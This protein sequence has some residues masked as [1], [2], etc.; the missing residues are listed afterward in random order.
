MRPCLRLPCFPELHRSLLLP[1]IALAGTALPL[2]AEEPE[3]R[4]DGSSTVYPILAE[5]VP[6]YEKAVQD[7]GPVELKFS[8]TSA[9]F[10]RFVTGE[11]D[12]SAASRP[13]LKEEI[14]KA[15]EQGV[16]FI[17]IPIAF[18]ALTVAVNKDNDWATEIKTSELKK[19][20]EKAAEGKITRWNQIRPEWPDEEIKLYGAGGDSGTYDYFA[21]VITGDAKGLR[22]DFVGS[23][24]DTELV[25]GIEADRYALGF[26]PFAYFSQDK[27][28]LRA[29]AIERDFDAVTGQQLQGKP[30]EPSNRAV[31]DG[32][33]TPLGRP[34]FLYVNADS[35]GKKPGVL[36][37]LT[38]F[39]DEAER[40]IHAV[41]YLPLSEIS[42]R[43]GINDLRQRETGTRFDGEAAS[44]VAHTDLHALQPK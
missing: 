5:V 15:K 44:G 20:W 42:Y 32:I 28:Q 13:I 37:F 31:F 22:D 21:E 27:G 16:E 1:L 6:A 26:I 23:E 19:L 36:D 35:V 18:D 25:A 12:I 33:Y 3:V 8:G 7:A 40:Y 11:T 14:R 30:I 2:G 29:L 34:L 4:I 41:D 24:D 17:E 38:F 43:D 9:G 39:L 10:R